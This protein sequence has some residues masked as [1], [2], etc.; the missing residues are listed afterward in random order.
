MRLLKPLAAKIEQRNRHYFTQSIVDV[1]AVMLLFERQ[2]PEYIREV[3]LERAQ[4]PAQ[5]WFGAAAGA[6]R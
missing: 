3:M 2:H 4:R 1:Q 6:A 5:P